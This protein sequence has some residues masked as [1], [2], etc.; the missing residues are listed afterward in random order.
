MRFVFVLIT[1]VAALVSV[2]S[3]AKMHEDPK[4]ITWISWDD[5]P[6][7]I[8]NEPFKGEGL[9]DGVEKELKKVLIDYSHDSI[10]ATVPRVLKEAEAK[11]P[12]CNA[13]WLNTPEWNKLFYFSKPVSIIPTNGVL[14]KER[15]LLEVKKMKGPYS[16]QRFLD[17]KPF[18]VLG[19]GRLYGEGI[20]DV[21]IRNDY[22]NNKKIMTV[23]S[24]YLVHR[25][26][27]LDRVQY[28]LGYP[29]EAQYYNELFKTTTDKV[30]HLPLTDNAPFVEVVVACPRTPWGAKVIA[31]VNKVL[32]NKSRLELFAQ[33]VKRWLSPDD[34][35]RL[36]IEWKKFYRKNYPGI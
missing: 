24:S 10:T 34:Q 32:H 3:F 17:N 5:P 31:D 28:T 22:H 16:L 36:M 35:K 21:L 2:S 11:S 27:N 6:I 25:M 7:F 13:G 23:S 30:V 19:I 26:L 20:D 8:F 33:Y 4:K 18:W 12:I 14:I 9:L 29:F 1:V 15:R